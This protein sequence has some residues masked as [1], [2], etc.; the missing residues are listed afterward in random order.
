MQR[1]CGRVSAGQGEGEP[2]LAT[3][4]FWERA[5]SD[6]GGGGIGVGVLMGPK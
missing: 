3:L 4:R 5:C 2:P 1:S 6:P